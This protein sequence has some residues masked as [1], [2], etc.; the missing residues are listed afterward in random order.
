MPS[1]V[2]YPWQRPGEPPR[3]GPRKRCILAMPNL[4]IERDFGP[5][6]AQRRKKERPREGRS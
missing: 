1:L 2:V 6:W 5:E 3:T 4:S